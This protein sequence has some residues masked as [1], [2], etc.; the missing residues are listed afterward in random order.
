MF[1]VEYQIPPRAVN[2]GSVDCSGERAESL[3]SLEHAVGVQLGGEKLWRGH[4][5]LQPA[6]RHFARARW[7]LVAEVLLQIFKR[8][9]Q[10]PDGAE[11]RPSPLLVPFGGEVGERGVRRFVVSVERR[12]PDVVRILALENDEKLSQRRST[13]STVG[14]Q[15]LERMPSRE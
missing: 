3:G 11:L 13:S 14:I 10:S 5:V 12:E 15:F 2:C 6:A 9:V 7:N 1:V 8:L 4:G